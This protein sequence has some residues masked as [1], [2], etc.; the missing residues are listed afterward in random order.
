MCVNACVVAAAAAAN[1]QICVSFVCILLL[2][3][4]IKCPRVLPAKQQ[5]CDTNGVVVCT[6]FRFVFDRV[7]R[8]VIALN[9]FWIARAVFVIVVTACL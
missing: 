2:S 7:V 1:M 3:Y 5:W 4:R 6:Q 8:F 9:F